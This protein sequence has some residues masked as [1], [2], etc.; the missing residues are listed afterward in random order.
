MKVDLTPRQSDLLDYLKNRVEQNGG[1]APSLREAADELG[2]S[3]M[4]IAQHLRALEVK[5]YLTRDRR[6]GRNVRL[7][8]RASAQADDIRYPGRRVPIVGK[9]AAGLPLYAQQEWDGVILVDG[10]LY[11]GDQMFG[12]RVQGDSMKNAGILNDDVVI[13]EPRQFALDG[14][15]V[16]AL[17]RE[18]E[19]ATV[20]RFFLRKNR[21]ELHPEN[22]NYPIMRYELGEVL[23]QGKVM[24]VF[25]GPEQFA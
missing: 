6:Y 22:D 13:C 4:A 8:A 2:V 23:I 11:K 3:H 12:L 20:K 9:I 1:R 14:E 7:T 25:R 17:I 10:T 16:V 24:G 21:I 15:I 19:E 18:D 5:G